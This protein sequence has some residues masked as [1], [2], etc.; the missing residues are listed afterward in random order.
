MVFVER[1]K[2]YKITAK[3]FKSSGETVYS[4]GFPV[5]EAEKGRLSLANILEK[6]GAKGFE[7]ISEKVVFWFNEIVGYRN[8]SL[9]IKYPTL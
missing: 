2:A 9:G 8:R 5:S 4:L 7:L 3:F 1:V 6:I